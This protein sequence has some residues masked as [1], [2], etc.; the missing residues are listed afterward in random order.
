MANH[1]KAIKQNGTRYLKNPVLKA[2]MKYARYVHKTEVLD[3]TILIESYQGSKFTHSIQQYLQT[4]LNYQNHNLFTVYIVVG[5][6]R[7]KELKKSV[8]QF[9][10]LNIVFVEYHSK[11]YVKALLSSKY[12]FTNFTLP[13]YYQKNEEQVITYHYEDIAYQK[14]GRHLP[15]QPVSKYDLQRAMLLSNYFIASSKETMEKI[16]DSFDLNSMYLGSYVVAYQ[17]ED[18]VKFIDHIRQDTKVFYHFML[19]WKY[20]LVNNQGKDYTKKV[21]SLLKDLDKELFLE[22][23]LFVVMDNMFEAKIDFKQFK[24]IKPMYYNESFYNDLA[25]SQGILSDYALESFDYHN[26]K[27]KV[28]M[29]PVDDQYISTDNYYFNLKKL[30]YPKASNALDALTLL[31]NKEEA[32]VKLNLIKGKAPIQVDAIIEHILFKR[33]LLEVLIDSNHF[34]LKQRKNVL[35]F[36]GDMQNSEITTKLLEQLKNSN[37]NRYHF[38]VLFYNKQGLKNSDFIN[39]LPKEVTL[40]PIHGRKVTTITEGLAQ[41]L[42]FRYDYNKKWIQKLLDRC[43]KREF[44]RI[45]RG[46]NFDYTIH[47]TGLEK[48]MLWLLGKFNSGRTVFIHDYSKLEKSQKSKFHALSSYYAC[49]N[50]EVVAITNDNSKLGLEHYLEKDR[51]DDVV[52]KSSLDVFES[53]KDINNMNDSLKF[54]GITGSNDVEII[55]NVIGEHKDCN[56]LIY[57]T[58]IARTKEINKLYSDYENVCIIFDKDETCTYFDKLNS[59]LVLDKELAHKTIAC[60]TRFKVPMYTLPQFKSN[61]L[62][63]KGYGSVLSKKTK[64]SKVLKVLVKKKEKRVDEKN[65]ILTFKIIEQIY[66][67]IIRRIKSFKKIVF[68]SLTYILKKTAPIYSAIIPKNKNMILYIAYHGRGY[69]D[70]PMALHEFMINDDKYS[71][72]KHVWAIKGA[73]KTKIPGAKV[74]RYGGLKYL[75]TLVRAKY[76]IS[77]CKLP[78]YVYKHKNQVYLQ[79]WH[80]TPLKKLAHDIE[81]SK[82]TTFYRSEMSYKEMANTYTQDV[83]KYDYMISP[84]SFTTEVF[85]SAFKI[86]E[87][88]LIETGYP[89]NDCLSKDNSK[90]IN[91]LK[92]KYNLPED[93]KIILYAPTWRDNSYTSAGYTFSLEVDFSMWKDILG[94]EYIVLF[95]PHYLIT[96]NIDLSLYEGF[97][98]SIDPKDDISSLYIISDVLITDYSSVFFDYSILNRPTYFYM[99][100]LESYKNEL[101]GFYI[102]IYKDLPGDIYEK[103]KAM[104]NDIKKEKF[105]YKRLEIFNQRFNNKEDGNACKRVLDIL[106]NHNEN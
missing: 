79:T 81:V 9:N 18:Y 57:L 85:R 105:D 104:L 56:I 66:L 12:I 17:S 68:K 36:A 93:K 87:E 95:K 96:N 48:Y 52:T 5:K 24:N 33:E 84:N 76:W 61:M 59:L 102:D 20:R 41:Y 40:L 86:N 46:I 47:Y 89:R 74:I 83:A 91:E 72:Y 62:F 49:V 31:R 77:N 44:D 15:S 97:V 4:L 67:F 14:T 65:V 26:E 7:S 53:N 3:N 28:V 11:S 35:L 94:D 43:Y 25:S 1:I 27:R 92:E 99:Y 37:F 2:S 80:G 82:D 75:Y 60:A 55:C 71:N 45:T 19:D 29:L 10:N 98:Y 51:V 58:D 21:I 30:P 8:D 42:Y 101:R 54:I 22:E 32:N 38:F 23:T 69:L 13:T 6:K 88:R 63:I 16:I 70:N 78:L 106:L 73:N 39:Q 90:M 103:E 50:Y 64:L 100:D 34:E